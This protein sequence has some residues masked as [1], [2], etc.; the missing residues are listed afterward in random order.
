MMH[1]LTI[2]QPWAF[3]IAQD[4]K[5]IEN[6]R[7]PPTKWI[8]GKRLA[9]HA[10]KKLDEDAMHWLRDRGLDV[11][12]R[13]SLPMG[14]VVAVA[15]VLGWTDH[16]RSS[17]PQAKWFAGPCGWVLDEVVALPQPVVCRGYQKLWRLPQDVE[18]QVRVQLREAA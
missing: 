4:T 10:G 16:L 5:R 3:C 6:R 7:W 13:S 1:A 8:I 18:E 17:H 12:L 9:I 14:T 11:P 2:H 15:K